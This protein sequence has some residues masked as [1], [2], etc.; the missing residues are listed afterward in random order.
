MVGCTEADS[1][2]ADGFTL[3][4]KSMCGRYPDYIEATVPGS[5]FSFEFTGEN[6]GLYWMMAKDSGDVLVSV[7][8]GGERTLRSWDHYCKSFNRAKLAFIARG[9][10]YGTHKVT[11]RVAETKAEESEGTAVRIGAFLLA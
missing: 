4:K 1:Y 11:V 5:T 7:D 10:P 2:E 9:L 8:G 3:V 6:C